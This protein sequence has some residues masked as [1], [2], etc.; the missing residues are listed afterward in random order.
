M[1]SLTNKLLFGCIALLWG[2]AL[3]SASGAIYSKHRARELFVVLERLNARRDNLGKF[4]KDHWGYKHGVIVANAFFEN[5]NR[6]RAEGRDLGDTTTLADA[7]V[8]D[9]IKRR[10]TVNPTEE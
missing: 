2:A 1:S 8:V 9:E 4:W 3:A 5:V 6:H 7:A 10:A